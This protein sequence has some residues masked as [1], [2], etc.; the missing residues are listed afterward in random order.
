MVRLSLYANSKEKL[1]INSFL[2]DD[3][4]DSFVNNFC[5]YECVCQ[6]VLKGVSI[7]SKSSFGFKESVLVCLYLV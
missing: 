5:V 3:S 7:G 4:K 6:C 1:Y 2:F